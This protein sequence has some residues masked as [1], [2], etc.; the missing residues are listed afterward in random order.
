VISLRAKETCSKEGEPYFRAKVEVDE[1]EL[2]RLA[3][4][5]ELTLGTP[6]EVMILT[7]ERTM[8]DYLVRP[9][10]QSVTRSFRES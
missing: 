3:P 8:L 9:F 6:A 1:A 5:I 10:I 4:E 2:Q 7:G